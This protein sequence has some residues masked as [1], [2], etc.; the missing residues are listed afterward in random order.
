MEEK[1]AVIKLQGT[2]TDKAA[3][4]LERTLRKLKKAKDVKCLVLRVDSPGGSITACETIYQEIRDLPQKVVVSFGNYS[5]SG[6]YYI[7]TAADRILA[8]PT[9][10]TGSI[11]VFMIRADIR[12]FAEQYGVKFD[13]I[14]TS[15]LSGS[16]DPFY[17]VNGRMKDNFS[18]FVD[19]AY[20]HFKTLVSDGRRMSMDDVESVAQGRVWTGEQAKQLGLVDELGGLDRA[21]AYAQRNFTSSGNA[22]VVAW[23]PSPSLWEYLRK[24]NSDDDDHEIEI[25]SVWLSMLSLAEGKLEFGGWLASIGV[26]EGA[27]GCF[28]TGISG[29]VLA[30]DENSAIRCLLEDNDMPDLLSGFPSDFWG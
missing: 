15:D 6:G 18:N 22:T 10:I 1:I 17:P 24:R 25:P 27:T 28:P 19:R 8:S 13:S 23:P 21:V 11:G 16:Y 29:L 2:I 26:K 14:S 3:R 20:L 9:T 5:A 12:G 7:S 4:R 30:G